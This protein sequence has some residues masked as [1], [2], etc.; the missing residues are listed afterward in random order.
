M[1][2]D[3]A[4]PTVN[5]KSVEDLE[6]LIK[7]LTFQYEEKAKRAAELE[8]ANKELAFQKDEKAKRA[9]ELEIANKVISLG[10]E[11]AKI[12]VWN[13]NIGSNEIQWD[14]MMFQ[15]YGMPATTDGLI[16]YED[17]QKHVHPDDFAAQD[18]ALRKTISEIKPGIR[19]F[20]II[21]DN[22]RHVRTIHA[23]D[24]PLIGAYGR[25]ERVVGINIDISD[26]VEMLDEIRHL[27]THITKRATELEIANKELDSFTY[28]VSHD[29]RAPLRA[30]DGF[31]RI[32]E[33]DY[34][35][36]IDKNG[37]R[38]IGVIRENSQKMGK[39]IDDLLGLSRIGRKGIKAADIGMK[40]MASAVFSELM[41][42]NPERKISLN[43]SDLPHV[44]ADPALMKQ[45]WMN[46]LSNAIK[47]TR[48]QESPTIEVASV[49]DP[50]T[51]E[52]VFSVKDNGIGF[53]MKFVEKLFGVF[54]RLVD[55]K[56]FEG[57]GCGLAI[58]RRIIQ[59][60]GGR[61]WAEGTPNIG[62]TFFFSLPTTV[63]NASDSTARSSQPRKPSQ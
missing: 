17:W 51:E 27:N 42:L 14:K 16:S 7:E 25:V 4:L 39:L 26:N 21:R 44:C 8:I 15:I 61:I 23:S 24:C 11:A 59:R 32:L 22:D 63:C 33:E 57:T 12:G 41:A 60:H 49:T 19:D 38:V 52:K 36:K 31:S 10:V 1:S 45:V 55:E 54:E 9:A 47:F 40:E 2:N 48:K 35:P 20:R 5:C 29:L 62:A 56:E 13:W 30:I 43:I 37:I 58:V 53:D 46:L 18:S 6:S 50:L 34:G 3:L 28:S